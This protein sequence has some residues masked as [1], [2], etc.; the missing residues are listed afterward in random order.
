MAKVVLEYVQDRKI[1][2]L[3]EEVINEGVRALPKFKN[4]IEET[5][6]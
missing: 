1:H 5:M 2:K 4:Y 6:I 3:T